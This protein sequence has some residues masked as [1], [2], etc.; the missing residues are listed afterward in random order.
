[1]DISLGEKYFLF[2]KAI[3]D[4]TKDIVACY[5]V[6]IACYEALGMD[7]LNAYQK[8]LKYIRENDGIVI[9]DIKRGDISSTAARSYSSISYFGITLFSTL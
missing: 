9:A 7:G 6:Q 1:M 2:N 8:T 4:A 5:K 3:I